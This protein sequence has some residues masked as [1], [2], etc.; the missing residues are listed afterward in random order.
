MLLRLL[1]E[2]PILMWMLSYLMSF[3]DYL[4][5]YFDLIK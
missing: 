4:P 5:W 1:Q 3:L 2:F